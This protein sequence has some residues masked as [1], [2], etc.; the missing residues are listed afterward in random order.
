MLHSPFVG[1]CT[2]CWSMINSWA[3]SN[4]EVIVSFTSSAK[5]G[6]L[7]FSISF[8]RS[9]HSCLACSDGSHYCNNQFP[10]FCLW[11]LGRAPCLLL[12]GLEVQEA[13]VSP[14]VILKSRF[15]VHGCSSEGLK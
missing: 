7:G 1:C 14:W 2:G 6:A 3:I 11:K 8:C 10:V 15:S 4:P 13:T 9:L 5:L 12:S